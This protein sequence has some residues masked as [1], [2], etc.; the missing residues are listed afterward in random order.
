MQHRRGK[1]EI[2]EKVDVQRAAVCCRVQR[3]HNAIELRRSSIVTNV[4]STPAP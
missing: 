3:E 2:T 4:E 1:C